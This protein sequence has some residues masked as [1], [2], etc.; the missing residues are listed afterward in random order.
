[1]DIR[2]VI[3]GRRLL[4]T[5]IGAAAV[6]ATRPFLERHVRE[7]V[8][9]LSGVELLDGC[10][11]V[12]LLADERGT[13]ITGVRILRRAPG[14]AVEPVPAELVVDATGRGSRTPVWLE[15]LG[16]ERPAED[17]PRVDLG[18]ASRHLRLTPGTDIEPSVMVGA[19]PGNAR[20]M[21]LNAVEGGLRLLTLTGIGHA[22]HPPADDE[23]FLAFAAAIAP[24]DVAAAIRAAEPTSEIT[25]Y[26]YPAY[27]RRHYRRL[28]R[29]P[30]GLLVV[31]DALCSF[32]PVYAQG[33][34][35]AAIEALEL[36]RCLAGGRAGLARRY[37]PA[38][39]RIVNRA[40][41][42]GLGS[43]LALPEVAGTRTLEIRLMN[44]YMARLLALA[45]RDPVV[46]R[47]FGRVVGMLDAPTALVRPAILRRV[48]SAHRVRAPQRSATGPAAA[49]VGRV[50]P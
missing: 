19:V 17:R 8:E 43:D 44:A 2:A 20:G 29:F 1:V 14:S 5:P 31:G 3:G 26:R 47:Q 22:N 40:W 36:R 41:Q 25:R 42:M 35:V 9:T 37:F 30:D 48:L 7:R 13:D 33:M 28:R 50:S 23:G 6:Q 39:D 34:T 21:V 10:D 11:V 45:E 27:Q 49:D 18:Y 16:Y 15:A 38:V 4:H 12:G 32:N 46:A 24:P